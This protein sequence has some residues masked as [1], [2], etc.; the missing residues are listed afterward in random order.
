VADSGEQDGSKTPAKGEAKTWRRWTI[1][2]AALLAIP[3][4][5][6]LLAGDALAG[7]LNAAFGSGP[8]SAGIFVKIA[9]IGHGA[10]ALGGAFLLG[11][12]LTNA[13][14]RR[15]A[16]LAAWA[17]IPVGIGWFFLWGRLAAG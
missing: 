1:V 2:V 6:L 17:I 5:V 11:V 13:A 9:M 10:L 14:R 4:S 12:G 16:T 8:Q 7:V 15:A 3:V